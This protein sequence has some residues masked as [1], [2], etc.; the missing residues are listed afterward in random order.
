M[1]VA[2][3]AIARAVP[4]TALPTARDK[5]IIV[6]ALVNSQRK[7]SAD[8]EF[9]RCVKETLIYRLKWDNKYSVAE[10]KTSCRWLLALPPWPVLPQVDVRP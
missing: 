6:E 10:N 3:A 1:P 2:A 5:H 4:V 8:S 9:R 7:Q